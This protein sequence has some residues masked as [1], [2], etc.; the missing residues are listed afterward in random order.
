MAEAPTRP[1]GGGTR[2]LDS[3]DGTPVMGAAGEGDAPGNTLDVSRESTR[4]TKCLSIS[5]ISMTS[6]LGATSLPRGLRRVRAEP[7]FPSPPRATPSALAGTAPSEASNARFLFFGFVLGIS[8]WVPL[9]AGCFWQS[10]SVLT[11]PFA[12]LDQSIPCFPLC[13]G[14]P[15]PQTHDFCSSDLPWELPSLLLPGWWV[16]G[17]PVL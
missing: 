11:S 6:A 13:L 15:R 4:L 3:S 17:F 14:A 8:G 10:V 5:W 9:A 12:R 7:G 16:P 2:A 1:G